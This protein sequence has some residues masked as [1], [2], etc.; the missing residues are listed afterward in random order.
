MGMRVG[1]VTKYNDM[2]QP[3]ISNILRLIEATKNRTVMKKPERG[4]FSKL[5][6]L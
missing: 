4:Y 1:I 2:P 6:Y 3:I 5:N